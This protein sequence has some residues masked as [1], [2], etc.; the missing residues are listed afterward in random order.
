MQETQKFKTAFDDPEF[1]KLFA[2]YMDELQDPANRAETEAYITQLEGEQRV[3][4]GKELIRP[5][6]CFVTK[7][8]KVLDDGK[9]EKLFVNIV[10][11]EKIM[12]PSN[13]VMKKGT[14]WSLPYS[15]GPPHMVN[16][17]SIIL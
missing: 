4:E 3:P 15:L 9:K 5:I 8:H 13:E 16:N 12:R 10:S 1:R 7:M 2:D 11:S 14:Q 6:P 17:Y